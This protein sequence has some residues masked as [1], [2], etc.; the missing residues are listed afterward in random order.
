MADFSKLFDTLDNILQNVKL[1]DVTEEGAGYDEL[2]EGYYLCE[3]VKAELKETKSTKQ[4][5]AAFQLKVVEDGH[6]VEISADQEPILKD[7]SNSKGR[8]IFLNYVL[9]DANAVKRFVSDMLKFEGDTPGES[10]LPKEAFMTS[11][12]IVESIE[13]LIGTRIYCMISKSEK[14]DGTTSTWTNLV[15]WKRAGQLELPM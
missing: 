9:K 1:D 13:I 3:V 8:M 7:I 15:S 5:M 6:D 12:T 2:P 10:I 4:P 14:D 11:E